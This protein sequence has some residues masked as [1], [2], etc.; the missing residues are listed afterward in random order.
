MNAGRQK[1][2]GVLLLFLSTITALA[3]GF[4]PER[5]VRLRYVS[6][7]VSIQPHGTGDWVMGVLNHPLT[8]SDNVWTD[9]N[10]RAELSVG[11]GALRMNSET[12]ITLNSLAAS[13]FQ[14]TLHQGIMNLTVF[15]LFG[16]EIYEV[17]TPNVTFTLQKSGDYRFEVN[18]ASDVTVVTVWKGEG[19]A[20]GE[21]P[22]F[23]VR[24]HEHVRFKGTS[25][26]YDTLG[27]P[28]PDGFDSWC[29]GTN[30]KATRFRS[31]DRTLL[32]V[33]AT[34]LRIPLA[35]GYGLAPGDGLGSDRWPRRPCRL[36]DCAWQKWNNHRL[37]P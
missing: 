30:V 29:R 33:S 20:T 24:S 35:L 27:V 25:L 4:P 2:F 21:G 36:F 16:G 28:K 5:V 14:V 11:A 32:R 6:G 26:A 9:K 15:H 12:S 34:L 1:I 7:A 8:S 10:S 18:A 23:R 31:T 3:A 22:G 13:S 19:T 17:D 37:V